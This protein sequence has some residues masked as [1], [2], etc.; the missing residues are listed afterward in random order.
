MVIFE[1]KPVPIPS[2]LKSVYIMY[3][4]W[5]DGQKRCKIVDKKCLAETSR[6]FERIQKNHL[7]L[8][9][10]RSSLTN[11]TKKL[12]TECNTDVTVIPGGGSQLA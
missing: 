3:K 4:R 10:F 9:M 6:S 5:M 11:N 1:R 12:L 8:D 2:F 7:V